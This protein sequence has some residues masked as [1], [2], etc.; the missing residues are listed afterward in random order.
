MTDIP[1]VD[2]YIEEAEWLEKEV[3]NLEE[4]LD[5]STRGHSAFP[6]ENDYDDM[7][8]TQKRILPKL[9]SVKKT[10]LDYYS[11]NGFLVATRAMK[12]IVDM[13]ARLDKLEAERGDAKSAHSDEE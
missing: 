7:L 9:T 6:D 3:R 2:S 1:S 13:E 8:H 11:N 12:M 5:N 4:E 10:L